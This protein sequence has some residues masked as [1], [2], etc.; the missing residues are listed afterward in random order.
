MEDIYTAIC[1]Q[2][3]RIGIAHRREIK[4]ANLNRGLEL[5]DYAVRA[6]G[7]PKYAP[8]KIILF[9]EVFMQGWCDVAAPYS[10]IYEKVAN[11]MAIEIPGEETELLAQK[12][13]QYNTYIA[14]T[15]HEVIPEMGLNY[16]FNCGFL[17]SPKGEIVLKYHKHYSL[18]SWRGRDDISPHDVYDRYIKVMDG[19]YGRKKGDVLSCFFPVLHTEDIGKVGY[20]I[21]NDAHWPEVPRALGVQGCEIMLRSSGVS[22]PWGSPPQEKWEIQNRSAALFNMMYVVGC[23]PGD[24]IVKGNP[25]NSYP[26]QSMIV[27]FH[28]A[29]IQRVPYPGETVTGAAISIEALRKRRTDPKYNSLTQIRMDVPR[30]IYDRVVY[31][32]NL[33]LDRLPTGPL[34]RFEAQ[35]IER[36]LK[37]GIFVPP[38]KKGS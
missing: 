29:I 33:F 30:E 17:I 6:V 28:G 2:T 8:V 22:E 16:P 1:M 27:D 11:D 38:Y 9:P 20:I 15:A 36:Y 35:P 5:I 37:E 7:F 10:T 18:L 4:E 24:L 14:G 19:K 12:A 26:G 25:V 32:K 21:C 31:P 3:N 13:R 23:A 34:E